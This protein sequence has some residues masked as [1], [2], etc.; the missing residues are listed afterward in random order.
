MVRAYW[1]IGCLIVGREQEGQERAEYGKTV[2]GEILK[3]LA[4]E[5]GRGFSV[6]SLRNMRQFYTTFSRRSA[7]G[8]ESSVTA[9]L[10]SP[11]H[12]E[13]CSALRS[14]LTWT[15]YKML[16]RVEEPEVREP[17][18]ADDGT[19]EQAGTPAQEEE[20]ETQEEG[21]TEGCGE[22][23]SPSVHCVRGFRGGPS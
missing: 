4:S 16:M 13:K 12:F 22:R 19:Q 2:L 18:A 7:L 14:E 5:F 11:Q 3:R 20:R 6:Q 9:E 17:F 15:H 8:S 1:Q 21:P 23:R 10:V